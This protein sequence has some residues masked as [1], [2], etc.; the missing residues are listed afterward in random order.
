MEFSTKILP[1]LEKL[2]RKEQC[3]LT[4]DQSLIDQLPYILKEQHGVATDDQIGNN[5]D[6][7]ALFKLLT[8]KPTEDWH[9]QELPSLIE[10]SGLT[11]ES[12]SV[13]APYSSASM[14]DRWTEQKAD[15]NLDSVLTLQKDLGMGQYNSTLTRHAPELEIPHL[16]Y[17]L[18]SVISPPASFQEKIISRVFGYK[19]LWEYHFS[20]WLKSRILS[21]DKPTLSIG[22][23]WIS[24]R[25][26]LFVKRRRL[27]TKRQ[28]IDDQ[29]F[30]C[31]KLSSI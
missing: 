5:Q 9:I 25:A 16:K 2:V 30:G 26:Q 6:L 24:R 21:G 14:F 28:T 1:I 3:V 31:I 22:P 17:Y 4:Y 27:F 12:F 20:R 11:V 23:R 15:Q 10:D 18:R 19:T 8:Q 29:G 13:K 7:V